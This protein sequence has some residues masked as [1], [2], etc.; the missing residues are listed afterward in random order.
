ME[1]VG[2]LWWI[3]ATISTL[4]NSKSKTI[5]ECTQEF[6]GDWFFSTSEYRTWT[7]RRREEDIQAAVHAEYPGRLV[8]QRHRHAEFFTVM[9]SICTKSTEYR[10]CPQEATPTAYDCT[11]LW[12]AAT[13]AAYPAWYSINEW[14]LIY[15]GWYYQHKKFAI[16]GTQKYVWCSGIS[17]SASIFS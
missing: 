6:E 11:I 13:A 2:V 7:W 14:G 9:V 16:L 5:W 1:I 12:M 4:Q 8:E 3:P 15:L 10:I 17:P